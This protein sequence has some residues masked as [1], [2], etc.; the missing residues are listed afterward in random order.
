MVEDAEDDDAAGEDSSELLSRRHR[1][2]E[3]LVPAVAQDPEE[4]RD[5]PLA[6]ALP[7]GGPRTF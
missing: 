5:R 7:E 2:D 3:H 4:T 6:Q 1:V